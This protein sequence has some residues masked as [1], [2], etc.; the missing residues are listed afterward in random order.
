MV[1]IYT[2][3]AIESLNNVIKSRIK[4]HRIFSSDESALKAV[5]LT[6]LQASRKWTMPLQNWKTGDYKIVCVN[7][8]AIKIKELIVMTKK[9]ELNQQDAIIEQIISQLDLSGMTHER[10]F[11]QDG[12]IKNLTSRLLNRILEAEMDL[13]LGYQKHSNNGDNSG[14]SRNGYSRKKI[15]THDQNIELN[16]PRDRNSDFELEIVPKYSKR[17][18]LFNDQIISLYSC[19]MTTRDIQAHLKEIYGVDVSLELISRV[20]DAVHDDVRA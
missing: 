19:G 13:H 1:S 5:W 9:H 11:G 4:K 3:N 6:V 15:L 20:T 14:N 10:L 8:K 18:P 7:G 12:I 17:L 2:T 16:I